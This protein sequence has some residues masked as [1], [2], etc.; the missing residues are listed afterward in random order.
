MIYLS[1]IFSGV[2]VFFQLPVDFYP[3]TE[4]P[5][6][7]V[8][9]EYPGLPCIEIYKSITQ[10][11]EDTFSSL[12][13]LTHMASASRQGSSCI[14]LSFRWG[15]DIRM[16]GVEVREA[17]DR[18]LPS[19]PE[20]AERPRVVSMGLHDSPD[21]VIAVIPK[22]CNP[23]GAGT[24]AAKDIQVRF[25]QLPE[26][27]ITRITGCTKK[28]IRITLDQAK[29]AS[30]SA[31]IL[32]TARLIKS[33]NADYPAG[34]VTENGYVY[35]V[36]ITGKAE[37]PG[38][39]LDFFLPLSRTKIGDF[40]KIEYTE[41]DQESAFIINHAEG[42]GI[43]VF[44]KHGVSPLDLTRALKQELRTVKSLY[45]RNFRIEIVLDRSPAVINAL[46]S[47]SLAAVFGCG[48]AFTAAVIFL[49]SLR[50][51]L[52]ITL[53]IPFSLSF[54]LIF[55]YFLGT[56]LNTMSLSGLAIGT[57][58][59][60]DNSIIMICGTRIGDKSASV[61]ETAPAL[62]GG[63]ATTILAFFPFCILPGLPGVL[64]SDFAQAVI[65][66]LAGSCIY[67]LFLLP[68]LTR[69]KVPEIKHFTFMS[70]FSSWIKKS[71]QKK[72]FFILILIF[73]FFSA[74]PP[75]FFLRWDCFEF[76]RP[77]VIEVFYS[78]PPGSSFALRKDFALN[79]TDRFLQHQNIESVFCI[80]EPVNETLSGDP[81]SLHFFVQNRGKGTER[82]LQTALEDF[83][84][85]WKIKYRGNP[86]WEAL[87]LE[88]EKEFLVSDQE[89]SERTSSVMYL[90]PDPEKT[91]H[92][93]INC[94]NAALIIK[95]ALSGVFPSAVNIDDELIDIK[96]TLDT[97]EI[98]N[99]LIP[100]AENK[101]LPA[102]S[103]FSVRT[104]REPEVIRRINREDAALTPNNNN[105]I[106]KAEF[107]FIGGA[108]LVFLYLFLGI[109]FQSVLLPL[110]FLVTIPL[111][112]GGAVW[113]FF[114]TDTPVT[115]NSG[116]GFFIL[117]GTVINNGIILFV[118]YNSLIKK[119]A[120][121]SAA[122][123]RGT[124]DRLSTIILTLSTTVLSLL[125]GALDFQQ[126][127]SQRGMAVSVICGLIFSAF[128]SLLILPPIFQAYFTQRRRR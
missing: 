56:T 97:E 103:V 94:R 109:Q 82:I 87:D 27:G 26:V 68:A 11:L 106:Y 22:N 119:G 42:V 75:L 77:A 127:T 32:E 92:H 28:E 43:S 24:A 72:S 100:C 104:C 62:I 35:P 122:V 124:K 30:L 14:E 16:K 76:V 12:D 74:L 58:M 47:L 15:T 86:G 25:Q 105:L 51:G 111:S 8:V 19:L 5:E 45:S 54:S 44:K 128:F 71:I 46:R 37:E 79:I 114:L 31:D 80:I 123:L 98:E 95:A 91:V 84:G 20:E 107:L 66:A 70:G 6:L 23:A 57:G 1:F 73:A 49:R 85:S 99:I 117:F 112:W 33:S 120:P 59:V 101:F 29:A 10:I 116:F 125:P 78:P 88:P 115:I 83:T 38:D 3:E 18:A 21:I 2:I 48:A 41:A 69:R 39:L 9:T 4:L 7:S 121:V 63:T 40:A 96:V 81:E 93:G 126:R 90:D 110:L 53:T 65:S 67:A 60:V 36:F 55:L 17:V 50:T 118:R 52:L 13:S 61:S 34:S 108:T 89:A 102:G 113:A 64:F